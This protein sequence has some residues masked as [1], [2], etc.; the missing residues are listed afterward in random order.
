MSN[1][2]IAVKVVL[3]H[4]GGYVN[5]PA[6]PGGETNFGVT[7]KFLL[8]CHE[9]AMA[10]DMHSMTVDQAKYIYKKYW[11]TQYGYEAIADL[12]IATKTFDFSVN[13]GSN[14]AH[15][16]LQQALNAAFNM[17]LV[18][19][20]SLGPTSYAKLNS[21]TSLEDKQKLITSF[22]DQAWL[23]Y[24]S[25]IANKPS[26]AEFQNGWKNRA[27]SISKANSIS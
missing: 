10:I 11:W 1:F 3:Q 13:M 17:Q 24:Q 18:V 8:A 16:L 15:K 12:T 7:K 4:E 19:D 14:R 20:G 5:N 26:L 2:D 23:Y 25:L 9:D 21:I 27:Y 6:D 22:C